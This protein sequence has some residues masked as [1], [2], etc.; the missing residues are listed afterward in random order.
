M[1]GWRIFDLFVPC[2]RAGTSPGCCCSR[3]W[4]LLTLTLLA[5]LALLA[6]LLLPRKAFPILR[7]RRGSFARNG[8]LGGLD[9]SGT[10]FQ[11]EKLLWAVCR[12]RGGKLV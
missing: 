7:H 9:M 5:L 12:N 8:S 2:A 10:V 6:G 1:R 11:G 3:L 4:G